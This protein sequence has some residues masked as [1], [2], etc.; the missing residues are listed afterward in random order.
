MGTPAPPPAL[1]AGPT[2]ASARGQWLTFKEKQR[3]KGRPVSQSCLFAD[4]IFKSSTS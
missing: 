2:Q 4:G 1:T 3:E